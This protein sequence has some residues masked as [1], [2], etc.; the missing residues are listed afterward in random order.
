MGAN[1]IPCHFI[2]YKKDNIQD[3]FAV[4]GSILDANALF[5]YINKLNILSFHLEQKAEKENSYP[6]N[7]DKEQL[8]QIEEEMKKNYFIEL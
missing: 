8:K 5:S 7:K 1:H 4:A 3:E 2:N 6:F